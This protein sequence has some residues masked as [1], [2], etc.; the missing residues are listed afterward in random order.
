MID[1]GRGF[2]WLDTGTHASLLQ[3]AQFVQVMET[4]TG[5][6]IA[7]LEEIALRMGFID[8]DACYARGEG[9]SKSTYGQY[10]ME[11]ARTARTGAPV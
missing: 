7:C 5:V 8:A 10:V 4:R 9:L 2:A 6:R 3:A 11:V 1:L